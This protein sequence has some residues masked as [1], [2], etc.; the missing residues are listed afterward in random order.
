MDQYGFETT[1]KTRYTC[2]KTYAS[3]PEQYGI[4]FYE[5]REYK[6]KMEDNE[7]YYLDSTENGTCVWI[8]NEEL[9]EYFVKK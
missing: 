6:G 2:I 5:G 4:D 8:T 3:E 7:G 9:E 1:G